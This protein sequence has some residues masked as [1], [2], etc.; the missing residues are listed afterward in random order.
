MISKATESGVWNEKPIEIVMVDGKALLI[1][2]HY[3]LAAALKVGY[4]GAIPY[5]EV[6]IEKTG[7]T[8]EELRQFIKQ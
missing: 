8:I 6:G 5:I 4:E 1:D 7:R 3:R 2:G